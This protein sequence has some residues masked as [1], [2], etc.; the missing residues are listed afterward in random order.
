MHLRNPQSAR[1]ETPTGL[2]TPTP[3]SSRCGLRLGHCYTPWALGQP[4]HL[5]GTSPAAPTS[6]RRVAEP[7]TRVASRCLAARVVSS[8][9]GRAP[10]PPPPITFPGTD[11][12]TCTPCA[13]LIRPRTGWFTSS[14]RT[15]TAPQGCGPCMHRPLISSLCRLGVLSGSCLHCLHLEGQA[16]PPAP[17]N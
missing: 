1:T 15:A 9:S 2:S 4:F 10:R 11:P 14:T 6:N 13:E 5:T 12:T 17:P 3:P 16:A 7:W 8:V